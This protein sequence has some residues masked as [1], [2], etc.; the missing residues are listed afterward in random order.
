MSPGGLRLRCRR[1]AGMGK[2]LEEMRST[3]SIGSAGGPGCRS[4]PR[5]REHARST[6]STRREISVAQV[7]FSCSESSL[8][9]QRIRNSLQAGSVLHT[10]DYL[11][12]KALVRSGTP[13]PMTWV[14]AHRRLLATWS[15]CSPGAFM[16]VAPFAVRCSLTVARSVDHR[17]DRWP[18]KLPQP[19]TS[20]IVYLDIGG[21]L[22]RS[23]TIE[24]T[25]NGQHEFRRARG[26]WSAINVGIGPHPPDTVPRGIVI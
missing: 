8:E 5:H 6:P 19:A 23:L 22:P 3:R 1:D 18:P 9:L 26:C 17:R 24:T 16:A 25:I 2:H 20:R 21:I 15:G 10:A 7:R 13:Y 14:R 12:E 11:R 4:R